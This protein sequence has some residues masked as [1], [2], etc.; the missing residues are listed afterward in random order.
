MGSYSSNSL[1]KM[2]QKLAYHDL[3]EGPPLC[4][5]LLPNFNSHEGSVN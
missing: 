4:F 1:K 2:S 3:D 5:V